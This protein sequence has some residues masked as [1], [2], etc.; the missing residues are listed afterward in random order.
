MSPGA[1]GF[2]FQHLGRG[3]ILEDGRLGNPAG[4]DPTQLEERVAGQLRCLPDPTRHELLVE[5]VLLVDVEVARVRVLGLDGG[6]WTQR[7]A[8]EESHLD[9]LRDAMEAEEPAP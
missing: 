5:L 2:A 3:Q 8:A 4:S 7:R 1:P 9:V 6:E